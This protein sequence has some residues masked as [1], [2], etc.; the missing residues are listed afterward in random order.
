MLTD[1]ERQRGADA[2]LQAER[3]LKQSPQLSRTFPNIEL[4][5][6]YAILWAQARVAQGA[7]AL[8][9]RPAPRAPRA[10]ANRTGRAGPFETTDAWCLSFS[11]RRAECGRP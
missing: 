6:A 11:D 2:L 3:D 10:R 9:W 5:D 1:E 7:G 8:P 4:V